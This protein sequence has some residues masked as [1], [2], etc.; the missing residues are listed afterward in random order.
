[1]W[2]CICSCEHSRGSSGSIDVS[3]SD[4]SARVGTR[5][6]QGPVLLSGSCVC[7][8]A[9]PALAVMAAAMAAVVAAAV[10]LSQ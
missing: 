4:F 5:H 2:L 6:V 7:V 1:M 10:K 3:S 8:F 9:S